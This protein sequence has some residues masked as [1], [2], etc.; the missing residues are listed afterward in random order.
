MHFNI[1]LYKY[2]YRG[3]KGTRHH[4]HYGKIPKSEKVNGIKWG[5][6]L[7]EKGKIK[8]KSKQNVL[9]ENMILRWFSDWLQLSHI[10]SRHTEYSAHNKKKE[11]NTLMSLTLCSEWMGTEHL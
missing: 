6:N 10:T 4:T 9:K 8:I 5:E 1:F 7:N 2:K 3:V 11:Q